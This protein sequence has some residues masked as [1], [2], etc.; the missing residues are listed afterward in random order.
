M[1]AYL[2]KK[3]KDL[4]SKMEYKIWLN[5]LVILLQIFK[6]TSIRFPDLSNFGNEWSLQD[7][8]QKIKTL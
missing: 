5:N 3:K 2:K 6:T 1:D 7:W 8:K 4:T